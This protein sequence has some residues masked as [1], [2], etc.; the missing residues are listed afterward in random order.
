MIKTQHPNLDLKMCTNLFVKLTLLSF[1]ILS[2]LNCGR[3]VNQQEKKKTQEAEVTK[4][5]TEKITNVID[6]E[7]LN[8]NKE[9]KEA[10]LFKKYHQNGQLKSEG[11]YIGDLKEGLHKEWDEHGILSLEGFY[12]NGKANG[13]MKWYHEK[14]HLAGAGNMINGI[15]EGEWRICDVEEN[16]SC[17]DAFFVNGSREGKWRIYYENASEK[18]WKEKT[19]KD[20]KLVSEKCWDKKGKE[21]DCE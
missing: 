15:R 14:G 9:S 17:I 7:V 16:G 21:I 4:Q 18:I 1:V 10:K 2:T 6:S 5:N 11:N 3:Q 8:L 20:D 19:W 13:L 12:A